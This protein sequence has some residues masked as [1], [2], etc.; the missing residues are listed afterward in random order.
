MWC[1]GSE[2][3]YLLQLWGIK[4]NN[5]GLR[6]LRGSLRSRV[7]MMMIATKSSSSTSNFKP[8]NPRQQPFVGVKSLLGMLLLMLALSEQIEEPRRKRQV[9]VA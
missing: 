8:Y 5:H 6:N 2:T 9:L 7:M 4:G 1:F 3:F